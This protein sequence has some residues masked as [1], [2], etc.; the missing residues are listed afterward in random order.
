VF[1]NCAGG[2]FPRVITL[3][4]ELTRRGRDVTVLGHAQQRP[5]AEAAGSEFVA[6]SNAPSWCPAG[7]RAPRPHCGGYLARV[8]TRTLAD[9]AVAASRAANLVAADCMLLPVMSALNALP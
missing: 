7:R 3:G 4:R 9:D 5:Q 2:N 6:N 8:T 1:V